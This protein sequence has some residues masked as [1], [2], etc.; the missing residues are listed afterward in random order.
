[1]R[2]KLGALVFGTFLTLLFLELGL[3]LIGSHDV[4]QREVIAEKGHGKVKIMCVG[5]S[6]TAGAGA[7]IGKSYPAQLYEILNAQAKDRYRV[8]NKGVSNINSTYIAMNLPRWLEEEKPDYVFI[9]AGEANSWN[10]FGYQEFLKHKDRNE[11]STLAFF[12]E[13]LQKLKIYKLFELLLFEFKKSTNSIFFVDVSK[14][15]QK[16]YLG[17]LWV[18]YL[19]SWPPGHRHLVHLSKNEID[20]ALDFLTYIYE[21]DQSPLAARLLSDIYLYNRGDYSRFFYFARETIRLHKYFNYDLWISLLSHKNSLIEFNKSEYQKL[22]EALY[23][24]PLADRREQAFSWIRNWKNVVFKNEE[25]KNKFFFDMLSMTPEYFTYFNMFRYF[26][27]DQNRV[28]DVVER[29]LLQNPLSTTLNLLEFAKSFAAT[30]PKLQPRYEALLKT[31]KNRLAMEN[32]DDISHESLQDQWLYRDLNQMIADIKKF[33]AKAIVQTYP[34]FRNGEKRPVDKLLEKWVAKKP[35]DVIFMDV[36]SMMADALSSR[37]NGH[38]FYSTVYGPSDEHLN[39]H[40]YK[41]LANLMV[42][43]VL[44]SSQ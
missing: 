7:P 39:E 5:N 10:K 6:H 41:I 38:L 1:M 4:S 28:M 42:P 36:G 14:I 43:Y 24:M 13:N 35:Q 3:R 19:G 18:G 15:T 22:E 11:K 44:N 30:Y 23:K 34:R 8:V 31:L 40:G 25:E 9:M 2:K 37:N 20:E 27:Y 32:L 17:Y 16:K 29:S 12:N 26:D 21:K 33:K